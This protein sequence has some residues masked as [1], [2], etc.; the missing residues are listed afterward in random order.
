MANKRVVLQEPILPIIVYS[1]PCSICKLIF[2]KFGVNSSVFSWDQ[3]DEKFFNSIK[4]YSF[5]IKNSD[6]YMFYVSNIY[7]YEPLLILSSVIIVLYVL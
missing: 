3:Y 2:F 7:Y 5:S 6:F 1:L 4:F